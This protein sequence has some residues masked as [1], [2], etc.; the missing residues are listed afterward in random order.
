MTAGAHRIAALIGSREVIT[1]ETTGVSL[2]RAGPRP[3]LNG[4][5]YVATPQLLRAFGITAAQVGPGT[6]ILTMRPGLAR[7]SKMQLIHGAVPVGPP[8]AQ[9]TTW[10]CPPR[11]CL[12]NPKIEEVSALPSGTS[13]PNTVITER[14]VHQFG[15]RTSATGW[16]IQTPNSLTAAQISAAEQAAATT[17]LAVET[18]NSIPSLSEITDA[19]TVRNILLARHPRH[20]RRLVRSGRGTC[21]LSATGASSGMRRTL[22]TATGALASRARSSAWQAAI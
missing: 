6:D 8:G 1:L 20:D 21:A 7:L 17:G 12:A 2:R 18:R 19:A 3:C 11:S 13:A 4:A 22:T 14:A 9:Q 15:V 5:V 16:L 10:P